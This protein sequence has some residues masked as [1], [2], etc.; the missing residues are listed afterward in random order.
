MEEI[1]SSSLVSIITP[2]YNA[3]K[4]IIDTYNSIKNQTY[5]NWEWLV[6]DDNSTDNTYE[7]L[8]N[9]AKLDTRIIL[10]KNNSIKGPA[11]ARNLGIKLASGKYMTFID[12]DDIWHINFIKSSVKNLATNNSGFS[13]SSFERWNEDFTKKFDD[14]IIPEKINYNQLLFTC[15]ISCLTAFIDIEKYG[16]LYMPLIDKRQDYALWLNYLKIIPF[17]VGIKEPLA[18]YRIHKNSLSSKKIKLIKYQ[19]SIYYHNQELGIIRSIFYTSTWAFHGI[20]KYRKIS[21]T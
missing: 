15:P 11:S 10:L 7:I 9:L 12:S 21:N 18:K 13:F 3:S 1:K 8:Q 20:M 5:N 19:F 16:K 6:I 14:F 4:Y 17:A 2:A